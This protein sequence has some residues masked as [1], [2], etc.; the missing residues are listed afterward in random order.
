MMVHLGEQAQLT[1]D[2]MFKEKHPDAI[3][4]H[5]PLMVH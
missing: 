3:I 2:E 1:A 5:E 4:M